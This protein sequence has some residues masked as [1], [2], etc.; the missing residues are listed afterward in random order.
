MNR[1]SSTLFVFVACAALAGGFAAPA[2]GGE[3]TVLNIKWPGGTLAEYVEVLRQAQGEANIIITSPEVRDLLLPPVELNAVSLAAAL[4]VM[5]GEYEPNDRTTIEIGIHEVGIWV[6]DERPV[7]KIY[8][9]IHRSGR[10]ESEVRV[11]TVADLLAR[12]V[13]TDGLLTSIETALD[14]LATSRKP[15]EMR[16]H[17]ATGLLIVCGDP[18]QVA[19]VDEV[20]DQL[21][22][23]LE[24]RTAAQDRAS[25]DDAADIHELEALLRA[26][27]FEV[28]ELRMRLEVTRQETAQVLNERQGLLDQLRQQK[29]A[30]EAPQPKPK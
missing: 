25:R 6:E 28:E 13:P 24:I 27:T 26:K 14:L 23:G 7:Y 8:G 15:A 20:V 12:E 10:Y 30:L 16:F 17:E 9:E 1:R 29:D 22:E 11:W 21:R 2:E 19:A 18:W 4:S 5:E 3:P